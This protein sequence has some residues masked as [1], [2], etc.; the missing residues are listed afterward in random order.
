MKTQEFNTTTTQYKMAYE[1]EDPYNHGT[2][3][4]SEPFMSYYMQQESHKKAKEEALSKYN[5]DLIKN[6]TPTGMRSKDVPKFTENV[7]KWIEYG[8]QNKKAIDNPALDGGKARN[9]FYRTHQDLLGKTAMSKNQW[10]EDKDFAAQKNNPDNFRRITPETLQKKSLSDLPIWDERY[11]PFSTATDFNLGAKPFDTKMSGELDKVATEGLV[12][13]PERA[14]VGQSKN[15]P[16]KDTYKFTYKHSPENMKVGAD[17]YA[18]AYE[19]DASFKDHI[20]NLAEDITPKKNMVGQVVVPKEAYELQDALQKVY[21]KMHIINPDGTVN[22]PLLAA[23]YGIR[24]LGAVAEEEKD[25]DNKD[26]IEKAQYRRSINL[27]QFE[28]DLKAKDEAKQGIFIDDHI[29]SLISNAKPNGSQLFDTKEFNIPISPIEA[30]AFKRE[31]VEPDKVIYDAKANQ[32][33]PIFYVYEKDAKGNSSVKKNDDGTN[34]INTDLSEPV[35]YDQ[36]KLSLLNVSPKTT[37]A[38]REMKKDASIGTK[39]NGAT[40]PP[41]KKEISKSSI[42]EKAGAAGYSVSQYTDL[43]KKNGVTIKD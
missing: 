27:K 21:P 23:A 40:A 9:E 17:R 22:K 43:L 24:R 10:Q 6:V 12:V 16:M 20:D 29:K 26:R 33:K 19:A 11:T 13:K 39:T 31:G 38:V 8:M 2:V 41:K 18:S 14:F 7:N 3:L 15:D 34:V 25:E 42:A 30:A 35:S 36:F 28:H 4:K 37:Q 32:F 1:V 5:D